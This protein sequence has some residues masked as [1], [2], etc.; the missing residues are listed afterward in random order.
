MG[1]NSVII[2]LAVVFCVAAVGLSYAADEKVVPAT[3]PKAA[4]GAAAGAAA[5]A[6]R[7]P[8]FNFITGSVTNINSSDAA[9]PAI[10]VKNDKDGKTH[11]IKVT[12]Y[13]NIIKV[14]ELSELK[15]GDTVRVMARNI[16]GSESAMSIT[17]GKINKM[18]L[19]T[20][21]PAGEI[22]EP[23]LPAAKK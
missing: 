17:F 3:Q 5:Q 14:T 7:R 12:P 1:K 19:P 4:I 10:E 2:F 9:N 23:V 11:A 6:V 13:T 15:P 18:M 22:S 21:T 8:A 16:E 20:A